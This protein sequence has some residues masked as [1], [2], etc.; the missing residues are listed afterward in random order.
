MSFRMARGIVCLVG[1]LASVSPSYSA[2]MDAGQVVV[3][4]SGRLEIGLDA[5]GSRVVDTDFL[6][7]YSSVAL[8]VNDGGDGTLDLLDGSSLV[9]DGK[10]ST[11]PLGAAAIHVLSG[12]TLRSG[13]ASIVDT[14]ELHPNTSN[15]SLQ[16]LSIVGQGSSWI[17]QG[18]F[19]LNAENM[20]ARV[21]L[22]VSEGGSLE[23]DQFLAGGQG[24][25]GG[26]A[27]TI[28]SGVG[29]SWNTIGSFGLYGDA[30]F[31]VRD[32]A[33]VV[34]GSTGIG[35]N[36]RGARVLVQGIGS[37]WT[38]GD[39]RVGTAGY[40][41]FDGFKI[42]DGAQVHSTSVTMTSQTAAFASVEGLG[43]TWK[44]DGRLDVLGNGAG[45]NS[46]VRVID[47]ALLESGSA[48]VGGVCCFGSV[49]VAGAG[50]AWRNAGDLEIV[51]SPYTGTRVTVLDGAVLSTQSISS[52]GCDSS[53]GRNCIL[54]IDG[55]GS[56]VAVSTDAQIR[57]R[58]ISGDVDST[59]TV[60]NGAVLQAGGA[61][62]TAAASEIRLDRGAIVA[63]RLVIDGGALSGMG[64]VLGDVENSGL[65]SPGLSAG[66]LVINGDYHQSS[67][68]AMSIELG[69]LTPGSEHDILEVMGT[70]ILGGTLSVELL[71]GYRPMQGDVFQVL[72]SVDR[73]GMF[74]AIHGLDLGGGLSFSVEYLPTGLQLVTIPESGTGLLIGG[75]LIGLAL[76]RRRHSG[77]DGLAVRRPQNLV[78][79]G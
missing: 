40:L 64:D 47:G 46:N 14:P 66:R 24:A 42:R 74:A 13:S 75:G 15:Y 8:G 58:G 77:S 3:T 44:V 79:R 39:L 57:G 2:V 27:K 38:T 43:S 36:Y 17:N 52:R 21:S 45:G 28:V 4:P 59:W 32:G 12:S 29:S 60:S 62:T 65:V 63:S 50:S 49:S 23:T 5:V 31:E 18:E 10:V 35:D 22:L 54:S 68:G 51:G 72:Q 55:P 16:D 48:Y 76:S 41:S 30:S 71:D 1:L 53:E 20:L 26:Y 33:T 34:S 70:S 73:V 6:G 61:V 78:G 25:G 19:S 56:R 37:N 9:V 11:G 7:P 67:T 69:G